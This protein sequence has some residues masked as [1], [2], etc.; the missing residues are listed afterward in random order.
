MAP[1]LFGWART[2]FLPGSSLLV[3][4][5]NDG[6]GP[7]PKGW[8][9]SLGGHRHACPSAWRMPPPPSLV[10]SDL[11]LEQFVGLGTRTQGTLL[12]LD[13]QAPS[14]VR[15]G[16]AGRVC[17]GH[18]LLEDLPTVC[19]HSWFPELSP[20]EGGRWVV[21]RGKGLLAPTP[22]L[23]SHRGARRQGASSQ[24]SPGG[25][26]HPRPLINYS[27]SRASPPLVVSV[28]LR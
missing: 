15:V 7:S 17:Q 27:S 3:C 14:R 28:L 5:V 20:G 19:P 10:P 26:R 4:D 2:P 24:A 16:A 8:R 23:P 18:R 11:A 9:Q 6:H 22:G 1:Q 25:A 13:P 21:A 12:A